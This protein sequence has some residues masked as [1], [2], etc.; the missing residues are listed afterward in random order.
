[1]KVIFAVAGSLGD[2]H[3]H[4][5]LGL[6]LQKNGVHVTIA[7]AEF[8][9]EKILSSGLRYAHMRPEIDLTDNDMLQMTMDLKNGPR[10]IIEG[11]MAP[12]VPDMFSDLLK[13]SK[14][15][16]LIVSTYLTFAAPMVAELLQKPWIG[17]ALAP[18]AFWSPYDMPVLPIS[19]LTSKLKNISSSLNKIFVKLGKLQTAPWTRIVH[20]MR[21]N[22]KLSAIENPL[23]EGQFSPFG[24]LALF[25]SVVGK[26]QKDWPSN[27]VQTGF[28]YFD[29]HDGI[30][31]LSPELE[32][33]LAEGTA[34]VIF[35]LG[36]AAVLVAGNFYS[37]SVLAL[38][39]LKN[40]RGVLLVGKE[41]LSSYLK[42]RNKNLFVESYAPYSKIFS[43]ASAIV[44]QGGIGTTAQAL[45]SGTPSLVVPYAN[46]QPDN[47]E[48]VKNLG[49][50]VFLPRDKYKAKAVAEKLLFLL[51]DTRMKERAK[52]V[53]AE[54]SKENGV[55]TAANFILKFRKT[56]E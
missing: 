17:S 18:I 33:F 38:E 36:S 11:I 30:Q 24:N 20:E 40:T 52:Q 32:K 49:T 4:M 51:S 43:R 2:L 25:S 10:K 12:A 56:Q 1:M 3:P 45:K 29:S 46:D 5:A 23:F 6:E 27:T 34:P 7:A 37:E 9:K 13:A 15:V 47:A 54:L 55:E 21:K 8:Y 35:T 50:G 28:C 22:L 44:H 16:D 26:T 53:A 39:K 14:D 19:P 42:L 31:E 41:N 48:R